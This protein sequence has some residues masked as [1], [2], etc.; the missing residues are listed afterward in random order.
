M[1]NGKKAK[2]T[3]RVEAGDTVLAVAKIR[4]N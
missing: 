1:R 4:G 3:D 2:L